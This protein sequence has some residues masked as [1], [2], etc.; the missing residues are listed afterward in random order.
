[1]KKIKI[2]ISTFLLFVI[3][4]I[5]GTRNV[6]A[7]FLPPDGKRTTRGQPYYQTSTNWFI[8]HKYIL[9]WIVVV[10]LVAWSF[11]VLYKIRNRKW[12]V[13]KSNK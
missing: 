4:F 6:L 11:V 5:L 12:K 7:D 8:N 3:S 1:M 10:L 13:K 2:L 9:I